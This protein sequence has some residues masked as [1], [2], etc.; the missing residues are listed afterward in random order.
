VS[1][2]ITLRLDEAEKALIAE[3]AK[4]RGIGISETLRKAIL[5]KIEDEIDLAA[6]EKAYAE[7]QRNPIVYS[8]EEV[9][10]MWDD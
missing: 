8:L 9:N 10:A 4:M 1:V 6:A 7:Y 3:Y 2:T 5:E